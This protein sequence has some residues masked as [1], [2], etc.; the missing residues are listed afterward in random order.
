MEFRVLFLDRSNMKK[1]ATASLQT[2][3]N[4]DKRKTFGA[5]GKKYNNKQIKTTTTKYRVLTTRII[6]LYAYRLYHTIQCCP[7]V[8][9]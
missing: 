3:T 2:C 6:E 7:A 8:E 1:I 5:Q 4:N 9:Q